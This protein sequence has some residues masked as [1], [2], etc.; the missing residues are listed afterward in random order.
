M[1]YDSSRCIREIRQL[2]WRFM[3][4]IFIVTIALTG[5]Y[6]WQ[7]AHFEQHAKDFAKNEALAN[8]N[9][10]QA[11]R[12]W[13]AKHG[14]VYVPVTKD[15]PPNPYLS[16]IPE[17]DITTPSGKRLTLMN[18]AYMLRQLMGEHARLYGTIGHITSL[19]LK[20][21]DN[22]PDEWERA[23]L[24]AFE[25]GVK[26]IIELTTLNGEAYLR[27][28]RPMKTR[29]GCL[30]CH[31]KQGY[32]VG[33]IRGGVS[34]SVP[35][36]PYLALQNSEIR[37][38]QIVFSSLW[39]ISFVGLSFGWH[40]GRMGIL[41]RKK[42]RQTLLES[43]G[44][45]QSISDVIQ[46]AIVL[47]G[48]DS[49]VEYWNKAAETIFGY[50]PEEALGKD[51]YKLIVPGRNHNK[52]AK[53]WAHTCASNK[54]KAANKILEVTALRHSSKEFPV[55]VSISTI[56]M[57]GVWKSV[58]V[59]RDI[60]KRKQAER[61]QIETNKK[62]EQAHREWIDAFDAVQDP[63]FLHDGQGTIMRANRAYAEKAGMAITDVAGRPYWECFPKQSGPLVSCHLASHGDIA[64]E[65]DE[66]IT[67][68]SGDIL[69]SRA[70]AIRE[71]DDRYRYSIHILE[72]ITFEQQSKRALQDSETRFRS[73]FEL[74][75]LGYQSLDSNGQ[76]LEVNL[77]WLEL[78]GY[79]R[80]EVIN[81]NFDEF[82]SPE[83]TAT[84][85]KY[86]HFDK[87]GGEH[88]SF[89]LEMYRKDGSIKIILFEG[90]LAYTPQN[91][92]SI[93][94]FI[95]ADITEKYLMEQATR[96]SEQKF[97]TIFDNALDGILMASIENRHFYAANN[98]IC[99][100]L[101]YSHQELSQLG[102]SDI[103]PES[104]LSY[105][106]TQFEKQVNGEI[107]LAEDIPVK[108][109]DGSVFYAD[110]NASQITI[111]KHTYL[112]GM[113]RDITER[114]NSE[115]ELISLNQ[116]LKTI[117][118]CNEALVH[119][120]EELDL[121]QEICDI[122]VSHGDFSLAWAGFLRGE[123]KG[124]IQPI[125]S[126][127]ILLEDLVNITSSRGDGEGPCPARMAIGTG[128]I[129]II[130]DTD[131]D[132]PYT[133]RLKISRDYKFR[134]M[135]VLPITQSKNT[136][137]TLI[138]YSKESGSFY[139]QQID[140]LHELT[141]DLAYGIT[142]LRG[143]KETELLNSRLNE[144]LIKTVQAIAYTL[145]TRDPYTA[146]HQRRVTKLCIV[147][148]KELG[149]DEDQ[150]EGLSIG[151]SIHD[152]GKIHIPAEI[153]NRPGQ[154]SEHEFAIIKNHAQVGYDI[155]KDIHFPWPISDMIHQHHER[156]NGSGYPQGLTSKNII[157]EARILAV[158]DVVEAISSHRPYRPGLGIN[159]A[160]DELRKN[161]NTLYDPQIVDICIDLFENKQFS[162]S[163]NGHHQI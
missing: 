136:L 163:D 49:R 140:L 19:K 42:A 73:L 121:T 158:A 78:L 160:L 97:R 125:A 119:A 37:K 10:D 115:N 15:T 93:T 28:M 129:Q 9:K 58:G 52:V 71:P 80:E 46:D 69:L 72:D 3:A 43:E 79:T 91:N 108:R 64:A 103:H 61:L 22:A 38:R 14:G 139:Q 99:Q 88:I 87:E 137:G 156:P 11:F 7:K 35:M 67:L 152:I 70:F 150:I 57:S 33:D 114:K 117:S 18:P 132:N 153:L 113:F 92:M 48:E 68:E 116:T 141:D 95:L 112:L 5:L 74:A 146:G 144:N 66:E 109:K 86:F 82:L 34:I 21:P 130:R 142:T 30:K 85:R 55:E 60:S 31:S 12:F 154:L 20:N 145:E 104:T 76:I 149:L 54:F 102:V 134:S 17:R 40:R 44:K 100:M 53:A 62:I 131:P 25:R 159:V 77:A 41:E 118:R 39:L 4:A 1:E 126:A 75:P 45:F 36:V 81:H 162:F 29:R 151:A 65:Y 23:G 123:E 2:T 111:D 16:E 32:K 147:I 98:T 128:K 148:A 96:D 127:G 157:I 84:F 106:K 135:V 133:F 24:E 51:M 90:R 138:V 63:I 124:C 120:T 94:H 83:G 105:A 6:G 107:S 13:A 59:I 56:C 89:E 27:L 122:L 26:E 161:R 155:I 50:S 47:I 101:G 8:F 143:R 110:I